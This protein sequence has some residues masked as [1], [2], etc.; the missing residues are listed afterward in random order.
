MSADFRLRAA[1]AA[2][3]PAIARIYR[4]YVLTHTSTFEIDPP[5]DAE[6]HA[7][8]Q[9]LSDG[10]FPYLVAVSGEDVQGF[11]YIGPY[12][13]RVA[14][15]FTGENSVYLDPQRLQRGI[16]SALML[17]CLA[18]ASA[19]GMREVVA[20]IGDSANTASIRLH[21]KLGFQYTGNLR[22]VGFK[23]GRWLDTV[24]MQRTL[25]LP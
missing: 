14:Y 1:G 7:R 6:M 2:D 20:V 3:I 21:E 16:G 4:H 22:N 9:L 15:R 5:A 13:A 19:A 10:G 11:C 12:R 17:E 8:W 25:T 18:L 23:F 24:I